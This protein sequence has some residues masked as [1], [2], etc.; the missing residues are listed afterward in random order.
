[1]RGYGTEPYIWDGDSACEHVWGDT[2][3]N[4]KMDS[5]DPVK[6]IS[7][8]AIVGSSISTSKS[9]I[10]DCGNFCQ[11]CGAWRGELGLEPTVHMFID[12]LVQV[13]AEVYRVL[14][15]TGTVFVNL[16]DCYA[17]KATGHL[18]AES[19][20]KSSTIRFNHRQGVVDQSH[21]DRTK[22]GVK[23]KSLFQVPERFGIAMTDQIGFIKRNRIN[24]W[25]RSAKPESSK[26]RFT[27]D[28]EDIGYYVKDPDHYFSTQ[29][30][31]SRGVVQPRSEKV[32]H[33]GQNLGVP[34]NRAGNPRPGERIMRTTWDINTEQQPSADNHYAKYPL[35]LCERPIK[36]GCPET[37]CADCGSPLGAT[38]AKVW[39]CEC[40]PEAG[41]DY[42]LVYDPFSG[43][44]T[45]AVV[46]HRLKRHFIGTELQTG[47]HK[48]AEERLDIEMA[49]GRLFW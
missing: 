14:K 27:R 18:T 39:E 40:G 47:Y 7:Q 22:C 15:P 45:T 1:M 19:A 21:F 16:D 23:E 9:T 49:R 25:K 43:T 37:V 6:K 42:G 33:P 30:E 13:F 34:I 12:H 20:K 28:F 48:D 36:A 31:K 4:K 26:T 3:P 46:A 24:W 10:S 17:S 2:I 8:G 41:V 11:Q 38:D 44:G 35:A 5:R 29:W 32:L